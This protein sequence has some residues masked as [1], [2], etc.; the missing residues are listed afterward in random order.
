MLHRLLLILPF[1]LFVFVGCQSA[2]PG[3][4]TAAAPETTS[5]GDTL[6]ILPDESPPDMHTS[7]IALD[8]A[9]TYKGVLPCADCE[10]ILTELEIRE[11]MTYRIRTV[12]LG[13]DDAVFRR[14]GGFSWMEDG[15][16]ILL[17]DDGSGGGGEYYLVGEGRLF[18]LD[19]RGQRIHGDLEEHYILEK[20]D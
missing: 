11:D 3:G 2:G 13:R 14:S 18:V 4:Q 6:S 7:R 17:D 12:Y 8:W 10:G 1:G 19:T 16:R 9:G 5:A 20:T 15:S